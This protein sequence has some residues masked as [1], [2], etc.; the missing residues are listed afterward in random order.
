M[1]NESLTLICP[2]I[3]TKCFPDENPI[4]Y[5]TRLAN[6]NTYPSFRWLLDG[7]GTATVDFEKLYKVFSE[8]DW[9][10]YS[11]SEPSLEQICALPNIHLISTR[12]RYCPLCLQEESYWRIGWQIK[13]A[14]ACT[15]HQVWL[16]DLCPH[17]HSE[18][19]FL[20]VRKNQSKCF[21]HLGKAV[22]IPAPSSIVRMQQFLDEDLLNQENPLLGTSHKLAILKRS[23]LIAFML[24]WLEVDE[25][26]AKPAKQK[27]QYVTDFQEKAIQCANA[28]FSDPSGFW[29]YLQAI[30]LSRASN[31]GI[32]QTRLVYFYREA[33][34]EF[35]EPSFQPLRE[36]VENYSAMNLIRDIT[37]KHTLFSPNAK[38]VQLWCSFQKACKI[39]DIANSVLSRAIIDKQVN[40]HYQGDKDY[41]KCSVYRPDLERILPHLR[42]LIPAS[43]AVQILGITKAQFYQLQNSGLFKFEVPPRKDYC[44][45]WQYSKQELETLLENINRGAAPITSDCLTISQIMQFHIRATI[46]MP[47]LQLTKAILSGQIVVRKSVSDTLKIRDLLIDSDEFKGWLT[48]LQPALEYMSVTETSTLLEINEEFAYQLVNRGYLLHK[49]DSRHA[50]VILP[51]HIRQFKLEYVIL[52]K[53]SEKSGMSSASIIEKLE[54]QDIFPVDHDDDNKLRQK[55]YNRADILKTSSFYIYVQYLP[56]QS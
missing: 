8:A 33:F 30:H 49:T 52:S 37:E 39:Y 18:L 26:S 36:M 50:K 25:V 42:G 43:D 28:L 13:L 14:V 29:R 27:L 55:L 3:R 11:Q 40:S 38:K 17:C 35:S 6:E 7:K 9:T 46:E 10:G 47:V 51:D 44:S 54:S 23:E 31:I 41:T 48:N 22:A 15:R 19:S 45:T 24:K 12:L 21:D 5:L 32:Q 20:K 4:G 53:L 16:H 56:E 2:P 34:K 1:S